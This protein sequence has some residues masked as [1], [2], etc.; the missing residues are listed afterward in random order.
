LISQV[1]EKLSNPDQQLRAGTT[2]R[3]RPDTKSSARHYTLDA[4]L[5]ELHRGADVVS[6]INAFRW[7]LVVG[8]AKQQVGADAE[9]VAWLRLS[10]DANRNIPFTHF[11]LA[12][13]LAQMGRLEEARAAAQAGFDLDPAFTIRRSSAIHP[14]T[15]RPSLPIGSA[16]I[17]ACAWPGCRMVMSER[18]HSCRYC[19]VC[20]LVLYRR[21]EP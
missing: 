20:L 3:R 16:S 10:I 12:A 6:D 13:A 1:L 5:R 11:S 2:K 19:Q 9:A 8:L 17:G 7:M 15:I 18:G 4:N 21:C 14:A